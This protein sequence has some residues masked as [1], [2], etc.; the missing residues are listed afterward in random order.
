[1]FGCPIQPL[2]RGTCVGSGPGAKDA[3]VAKEGTSTL[4]IEKLGK[5]RLRHITFGLLV[6]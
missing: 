6:L 5:A 2:Y 1:M 3:L 4:E